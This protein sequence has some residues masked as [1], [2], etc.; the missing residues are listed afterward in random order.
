[1]RARAH[2]RDERREHALRSG[3]DALACGDGGSSRGDCDG[4]G[5]VEALLTLLGFEGESEL[6]A[7]RAL[8]VLADHAGSHGALAGG[9]EL[10]CVVLCCV[11]LCCVV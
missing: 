3:C 5:G 1:M 7:V 2:V 9:L 8:H 4:V 11:V 10:C 6:H